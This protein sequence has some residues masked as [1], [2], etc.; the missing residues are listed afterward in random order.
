MRAIT[1]IIVHCSDSDIK[2]HDDISVIDKWHRE[3]GFAKVGYHYYIKK[4]GTV[5]KGREL[6][7]IGAHCSGQNHDSI[8]ICLGGRHNF[9]TKQFFELKVLLYDLVKMFYLNF[10]AIYPHNYFD[11]HKACPNFDLTKI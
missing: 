1:K 3:R 6:E 5:Q 9:T 10:D 7:E 11:S 8:G 2:S 4:D